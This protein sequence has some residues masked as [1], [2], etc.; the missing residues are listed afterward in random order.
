MNRPDRLQTIRQMLT[1]GGITVDLMPD[2]LNLDADE[3]EKY[4]AYT[5]RAGLAKETRDSHEATLLEPTHA[6]KL[7]VNLVVRLEALPAQEPPP[8]EIKWRRMSLPEGA[9]PAMVKDRILQA[10]VLEQA[11]ITRID[12]QLRV[13]AEHG[14]DIEESEAQAL[15]AEYEARQKKLDMLSQFIGLLPR[16]LGENTG[17]G[18]G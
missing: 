1:M 9:K 16:L 17:D 14:E 5:I 3:F 6:G 7:F 18:K 8:E 12:W 13:G 2:L 10:Y 4:R 11:E 15:I